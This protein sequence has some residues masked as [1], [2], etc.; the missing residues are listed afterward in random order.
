MT[1]TRR[2]LHLVRHGEV[3]NPD[4]LVYADLP[5]FGLSERGRRQGA[6]AAA[7]L[8]RHPVTAVVSSPLQRAVETA[9]LIAAP[10]GAEVTPVDALR[11]WKLLARWAGCRWPELPRLFPGEVEA[12]LADPERLPFAAETL[13]EVGTRTTDAVIAAWRARHDG[14][15]VVVGHQDPT[16]AARRRLTGRDFREFH[17]NKPAHA[18]VVTLAASGDGWAE[19]QVFSPPQS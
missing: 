10:H 8:S 17:S 12:Y 19:V 14:H 16:E 13:A 15:V 4:H 5:G 6:A 1:S 11:E 18:A 7:W 3:E 9:E 2:R